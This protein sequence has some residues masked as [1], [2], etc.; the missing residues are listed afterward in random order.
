MRDTGNNSDRASERRESWRNHK[1]YKVA[2]VLLLIA[3]LAGIAYLLRAPA[4][5]GA[6][7]PKGADAII[8]TPVP[9]VAPLSTPVQGG[10]L[11]GPGAA[12]DGLGDIARDGDIGGS[13]GGAPGNNQDEGSG[14]R[15]SIDSLHERLREFAGNNGGA[16]GA[17]EPSVAAEPSTGLGRE[18]NVAGDN[19]S[20]GADAAY[21][22]DLPPHDREAFAERQRQLEALRAQTLAELQAVSPA[23]AEGMLSV[24]KRMSEGIR[25]QGLPDIID[26]PKMEAML[27]G[28][29]RLNELNVA[30]IA[31]MGRGEASRPDEMARLAGE[32][33]AVQATI[34]STIYDLEVVGRL[35]RGELQ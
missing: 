26:M 14:A 27:L 13:R 15:T 31:E 9:G 1:Q 6:S 11:S 7:A 12:S 33:Q 28:A 3:L 23:D 18:T 32:I 21:R 10:I 20:G 30:L 17:D 19:G 8:S 2:L 34:P 22:V 5:K 16:L 25:A 24:I 4:L 35:M 29:K